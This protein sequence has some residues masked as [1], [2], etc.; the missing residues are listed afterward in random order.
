MPVDKSICT[1]GL[2]Y[3]Q[4]LLHAYSSKPFEYTHR[5]EGAQQAVFPHYITNVFNCKRK[6][7]RFYA[8]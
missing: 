6:M 8:E 4:G 2:R 3:E 1:E 5:K 7:C